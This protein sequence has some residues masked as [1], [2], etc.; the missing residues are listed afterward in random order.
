MKISP[1]I[2]LRLAKSQLAARAVPRILRFAASAFGFTLQF[3]RTDLIRAE[4]QSD[5]TTLLAASVS[6][7]KRSLRAPVSLESE[8]NRH[9]Q[10][11]I[12]R[13]AISIAIR[14]R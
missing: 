7:N 1:N 13:Q 14:I 5:S 9:H 10:S 2:T 12:C 8:E 11:A 3:A 4:P 6:T